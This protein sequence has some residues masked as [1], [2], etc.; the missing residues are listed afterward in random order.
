MP[1]RDR[2]RSD[3][4][5]ADECGHRPRVGASG[6]WR[7]AVDFVGQHRLAVS[8]VSGDREYRFAVG[9]ESDW[10]GRRCGFD[11]LA[12][13]DALGPVRVSRFAVSTGSALPTGVE[14]RRMTLPA[15]RTIPFSCSR[16]RGQPAAWSAAIRT[17]SGAHRLS[18]FT[19]APTAFGSSRFRWFASA[20]S[21]TADQQFYC[22]PYERRRRSIDG[23]VVT[24]GMLGV[25]DLD[26]YRTEL[27][28]Q[29]PR[30][31][32]FA[33]QRS[34]RRPR[35]RCRRSCRCGCG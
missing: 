32:R 28:G 2:E 6:R 8:G 23:Q 16:F 18:L 29:E 22:L 14:G 27:A 24:G 1:Q 9:G 31:V 11:G 12:R 30:P 15:C 4:E 34:I 19:T 25:R 3:Q 20:T 26:G 35:G 21:Q 17:S 7:D 10:C 5:G 33:R 13:G